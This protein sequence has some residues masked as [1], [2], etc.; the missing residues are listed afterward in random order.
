MRVRSS[1]PRTNLVMDVVYGKSV[2]V[3]LGQTGTE[4]RRNDR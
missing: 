2:F 4:H 1:H 3:D